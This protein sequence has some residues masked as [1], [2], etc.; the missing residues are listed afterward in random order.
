MPRRLP[1]HD[2]WGL[3]GSALQTEHDLLGSTP[4]AGSPG[5]RAHE[6][7]LGH[8]TQ[9]RTRTSPAPSSP[10]AFQDPPCQRHPLPCLPRVPIRCRNDSTASPLCLASFARPGIREAP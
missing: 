6:P 5:M 3:Q 9:V 7:H 4:V 8:C 1:R 10:S 2:L